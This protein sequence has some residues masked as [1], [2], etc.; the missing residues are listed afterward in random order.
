MRPLRVHQVGQ[1]VLL[2]FQTQHGSGTSC[3]SETCKNCSV[4]HIRVGVH[5]GGR[6]NT[7]NAV[8]NINYLGRAV[9]QFTSTNGLGQLRED[10]TL[11][12][13][14]LDVA[15]DAAQQLVKEFAWSNEGKYI[16]TWDS[17]DSVYH[18]R[19]WSNLR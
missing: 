10:C 16:Y 11:Y 5:G 17:P 12:G 3:K 2:G 14:L 7:A 15:R 13:D 8:A 9:T 1:T 6:N 18:N 19:R 4:N